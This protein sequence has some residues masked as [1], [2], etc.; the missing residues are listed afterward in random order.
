MSTPVRVARLDA[1]AVG[2]SVDATAV[3]A[4]I[5]ESI[6]VAALRARGRLE[7]ND[8]GGPPRAGF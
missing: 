2:V 3:E 6:L 5:G 1:P 8:S 4:W 7:S